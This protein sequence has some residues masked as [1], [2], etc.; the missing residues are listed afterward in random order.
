MAASE[1]MGN[2]SLA[3]SLNLSI[4]IYALTSQVREKSYR[5][6]NAKDFNRYQV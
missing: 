1:V 6:I 4:T 5:N 3:V 2:N